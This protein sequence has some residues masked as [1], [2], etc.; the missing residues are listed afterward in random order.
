MTR[1]RA[2]AKKAGTEFETSVAGFLAATVDDRI[3]RRTRNGAKDRGDVSSVRTAHGRRLVV[4]VKEYGGRLKPAEWT[5]EAAVEAGNDDAIAGVVVAKRRGSTDPAE[6][7]VLMTLA[8]LVVW[9]DDEFG[10]W[11]RALLDHLPHLVEGRRLIV[12]DYKTTASGAPGDVPRAMH[13]YGY[14]QQL[15]WYLAGV[16]S[17][18]LHGDREPA[19]V[20]I[21]QEKTKPYL[22]SIFQPNQQAMDIAHTRN[23]KALDIYRHCTDTGIW[24]G[25]GDDVMPLS[26]P[27]WA[28]W[29][30]FD[31]EER[32]DFEITPQGVSA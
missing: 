14:H 18:G 4:E 11:R 30:H 28:E 24:P 22:V 32:G 5:A 3:E 6:Q 25:Y 16:R 31:A 23:R 2:S 15:D 20:L 7:W 13:G 27:G 17:L 21:F 12:A 29:E 8:D 1:N 10:V 9:F 19:G 26:L